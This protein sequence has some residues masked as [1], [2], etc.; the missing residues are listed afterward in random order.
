MEIQDR[1][2]IEFLNPCEKEKASQDSFTQL[3]T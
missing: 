3:A 2:V 1:G